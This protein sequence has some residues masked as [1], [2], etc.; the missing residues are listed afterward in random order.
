[1]RLGV[2]RELKGIT[3]NINLNKKLKLEVRCKMTEINYKYT[4][5]YVDNDGKNKRI[6]CESDCSLIN[7]LSLLFVRGIDRVEVEDTDIRF[8]SNRLEIMT[9]S[10]IRTI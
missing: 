6:Q 8:D 1:M 4:I 5:H 9:K 10:D 7:S 3:I 2:L